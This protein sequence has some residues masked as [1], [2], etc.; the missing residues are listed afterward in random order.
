M[1][2]FAKTIQ[3][4]A[5]TV[6]VILL[7]GQGAQAQTLLNLYNTGMSTPWYSGSPLAFNNGTVDTHWTIASMPSGSPTNAITALN[8]SAWLANSST[9]KWI[10]DTG[11]GNNNSPFG[12]YTYRTTFELAGG[13]NLNAVALSFQIAVDNSLVRI[14]LNGV[15]TG[16]SSGASY[17]AWSSPMNISSGFQTGTN[18]LD[19]VINNAGGSPNPQGLRVEFLSATIAPE[20][21]ALILAM[22]G[23]IVVL[24]RRR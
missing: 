12:D 16:L 19:F 24:R 4:F 3:L 7:T 17:A 1:S 18:T 11:D 15:N 6:T 10:N 20:P 8:H 14:D 23:G 13:T 21:S 2:Y 9:S 5:T 22:L